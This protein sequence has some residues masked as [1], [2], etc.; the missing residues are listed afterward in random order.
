M[1]IDVH[2]HIFPPAVVGNRGA[3][4]AGEPAFQLLYDGPKSRMVS[5]EDLIE[6][7]D[8][9]EI[10]RA[11]TFGF[12]WNNLELARWHNDYVLEAAA[13]YPDRLVPLACVFPLD[14]ESVREGDR[15]LRQGARGLGELAIYGPCDENRALEAFRPLVDLVNRH[16]AFLLV[17]AN[18]PVGH[19]Y[20]GKAPMGLRFYYELARLCRG[21]RLILAHWGGGLGFYENLKREASEVLAN[22]FYDTAASPYLYQPAVYIQMIQAVGLEKILLG[23][24]FPLL[25]VERYRKEMEE[26]GLEERFIAAIMGENAVRFL[27]L[28]S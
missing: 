27:G 28:P 26:A 23:S 19:L 12:P 22:V 3:Y 4:F 1:K 20:P 13:R 18:E 16:N 6:A 24:D 14:P 21:V 17:H 2:T 11:V 9:D 25:R 5:V 15:C 8:R 7:M 10:D